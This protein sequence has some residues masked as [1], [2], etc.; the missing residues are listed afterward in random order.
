[1]IASR[2]IGAVIDI[3]RFMREPDEQELARLWLERAQ[4]ETSIDFEKK[5][6]LV[7]HLV[8][9]DANRY[10]KSVALRNLLAARG[11]SVHEVQI[12]DQIIR[13]H[14]DRHKVRR[15]AFHSGKMAL[16]AFCGVHVLPDGRF[17]R[18]RNNEVA[19]WDDDCRQALFLLGDQ[20][21]R[22]PK[23][24][25]GGRLIAAKA[26]YRLAH[27]EPIV[28][29]SKLTFLFRRLEVFF[30]ENGAHIQPEDFKVTSIDGL[31]AWFRA[32]VTELG[33]KA[34]LLAVQI[35][36]WE[37]KLEEAQ[38]SG[39]T[40]R[41]FTAGHIHKMAVWYTLG[42]FV[43][44]LF[45]QWFK[46]EKAEANPSGGQKPNSLVVTEVTSDS[47]ETEEVEDS[48]TEEAAA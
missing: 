45:T 7:S 30:R 36:K 41:I 6:E 31:Y 8:A 22:R 27:P 10:D 42:K 18:R 25:W 48:E 20:F 12:V 3:R 34:D 15:K 43:E 37:E 47:E 13:L 4:L 28:S 44:S 9:G 32:S 23:S 39:K 17:P 24:H 16:R 35:Q 26:K 1:M 29:D 33:E 5:L 40:V 38:V 19:N 2:I 11:D 21:N 14:G 46:L